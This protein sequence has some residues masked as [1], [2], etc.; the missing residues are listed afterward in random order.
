MKTYREREEELFARWMQRCAEIDNINPDEDFAYDGLLFRGDYKQVDGCWERSPGNETELWDNASCRLLILTKDTT[1]N[2]GLEDM[3]IETVRKNHTG[4][5]IITA[6]SSF[7]RNLT[8]WSYALSNAVT[9]GVVTSYDDAPDWDELCEHYVNAPIARVN[10]KKQI[11]NSTVSDQ[12]LKSHIERYSDYLLEQVTMYDADIILCCG[13][14]S[15]NNVIRNFIEEYYLPDLE[16][17]SESGWVYFSKKTS[18]IVIDTFHPSCRKSSR[19][20][21]DRMME[22]LTDFLSSNSIG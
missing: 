5:E 18:K 20:M 9:G 4:N 14:Q 6:A 1:R 8:L 15:D 2:G 19:E 12:V 11:G 7:Y 17:F 3:R 21:Y 16:R 10:C 13:S 22:D